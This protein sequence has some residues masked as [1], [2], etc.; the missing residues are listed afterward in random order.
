M[1]EVGGLH[2][3]MLCSRQYSRGKRVKRDKIG[4][5]F[6]GWLLYRQHDGWQEKIYLDH[7]RPDHS[8]LIVTL[9]KEPMSNF[10]LRVNWCQIELLEIRSQ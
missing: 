4:D 6:T 1:K 9:M 7:I 2:E 8:S 5:L 3:F 10:H